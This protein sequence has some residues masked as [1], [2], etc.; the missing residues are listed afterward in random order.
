MSE[1]PFI[2]QAQFIVQLMRLKHCHPQNGVDGGSSI[3]TMKNGLGMYLLSV[4]N[5]GSG[6]AERRPTAR[7]AG[8]G[9]KV[10]WNERNNRHCS[11]VPCFDS[12]GS[13]IY[14]CVCFAVGFIGCCEV[15]RMSDK[16]YKFWFLVFVIASFILGFI[17]GPMGR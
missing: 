11:S 13:R 2:V 16:F 6:M 14:N 12:I 5:A 8:Q 10:N 3:L 15:N 17:L 1:I 7:T 9:W 4:P